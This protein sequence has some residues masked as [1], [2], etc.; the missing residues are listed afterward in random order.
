MPDNFSPDGGA[1]AGPGNAPRAPAPVTSA[2]ADSVLGYAPGSAA[3]PPTPA[4]ESL[5]RTVAMRLALGDVMRLGIVADYQEVRPGL[6]VLVLGSGY[7]TS[8]SREYNLRQ[9]YAAYTK[10]LGHPD[11]DPVME[12]WQKGRKV[13]KYTRKGLQVG[14]ET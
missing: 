2:L 3:E 5:T 14:P 4:D 13:G 8:T 6:L 1:S 9:L 7:R 10:V 11:D 12:L